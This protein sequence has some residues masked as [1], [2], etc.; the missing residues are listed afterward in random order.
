M[1]LKPKHDTKE[2]MVKDVPPPAVGPLEDF[3]P[4]DGDIDLDKLRTHL[5]NEGRLSKVDA[6][7]LISTATQVFKKEPNLLDVPQPVTG[8]LATSRGERERAITVSGGGKERRALSPTLVVMSSSLA[9][10]SV[11]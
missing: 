7:R 6:A 4:E 1:D 9:A 11:R 10:C 2:R 3:W 8:T 5:V